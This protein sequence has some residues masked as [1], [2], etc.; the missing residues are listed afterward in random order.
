MIPR[1]TRPEMARIWSREHRYEIFLKIELAVLEAFV[2][3][4]ILRPDEY[5]KIRSSVRIDLEDIDERE[6]KTRHDIIAFVES[7]AEPLGELGRFIHLGLTSS[8]ILDT[9]TGVQIKESGELLLQGL[10]R[11]CTALKEKAL[12]YKKTPCIGRTH[13]V[14][15]EPYTLGLKFLR[16]Y[17]EILRQKNRL[18]YALKECA[19]G[20]ISGAVGTFSHVSPDVE[21]FVCRKLGI[22]PEP[23]ASQIVHRDRHA[24][25]ILTLALI[26]AS[27]E[28]IALE[29]RHL[30]RTEVHELEEPFTKGQ[31]GSSAMPH[32]K[33]P[34]L[35][36]RICGMAR[37]LRGFAIT[38]LEN[39]ALWHERDI[40]H[41]STERIILP[42]ASILVD[43]MLDKTAWMIENL[44]VFPENIQKNLDLTRG[45]P[46]SSGILV[47]LLKRGVPRT[48]AYELVQRNAMK[49]WN[50]Q[51]SFL[52]CLESDEEVLQWL[53]RDELCTLFSM[54]AYL[55][56]IDFIYNRVL[57]GDEP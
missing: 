6:R 22:H 15:A 11:L 45:L 17:A 43:Y 10:T 16:W 23:V 20:K 39:V 19:V 18:E 41:S 52:E 4:G 12:T 49:A 36:E 32:K 38:A 34:I 13:G 26:G 40:S 55:S 51:R 47:E 57:N 33:N 14:H 5:E 56:S 21:T 3:K 54:D 50:E 8:D 53:S 28:N 24:T 2:E 46:F 7:L 37:L 25:Y 31:K 35:S 27:L 9:A 30:Q 29:I 44:Q 48:T 1:Y 42:D